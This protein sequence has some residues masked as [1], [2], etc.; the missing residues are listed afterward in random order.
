MMQTV[1]KLIT[2]NNSSPINRLSLEQKGQMFENLIVFYMKDKI[3]LTSLHITNFYISLPQYL[4]KIDFTLTVKYLQA[5][6]HGFH[7]SL[8]SYTTYL[9]FILK[10]SINFSIDK[11]NL[12]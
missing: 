5:K 4:S 12:Y 3:Y 6:C 7:Q 10:V 9:S 2:P 8:F 11:I 1:P